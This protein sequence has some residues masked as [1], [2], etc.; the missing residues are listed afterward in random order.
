[1]MRKTLIGFLNS[2]ANQTDKGF[3]LFLSYH[4]DPGI[5]RD[6]Y[7][8]IQWRKMTLSGET[9][10][11]RMPEALPKSVFDEIKYKTVPYGTGKDDL[12]RKTLTKTYDIGGLLPQGGNRAEAIGTAKQ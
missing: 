7:P 2:L 1:M 11:T 3:R 4:N 10:T 12:S 5:P 8:F 9:K 6:N